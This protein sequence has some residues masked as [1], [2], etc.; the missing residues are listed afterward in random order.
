MKKYNIL[1][2]CAVLMLGSCGTYAGSG[3]YTGGSLGSILGSTIGGITG[4]ARGSD[5]GSIIG[6]AGGAAVGAAIGT[7]ADQR[8][9]QEVH[10][11][12]EQVQENKARGVNPYNDDTYGLDRGRGNSYS[13]T[14]T[15]TLVDGTDNSG[16]D[17]SGKGDDR[18]YDFQSSD[19][20]GDYSAAQPTTTIPTLSSMENLA[21]PYSFAS[22]IEI[23]NAR[24]VDDNQDGMLSA[25]EIG[26]VIFEIYNRGQQTIYDVQPS[27]IEST[28]NRHIYISPSIHVESIAP[29]K[30]IRYTAVI[31]ADKKLKNGTSKFAL[32]VLQ[33]N[34][35][36]SKV[37]EFDI[38]TQK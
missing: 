3:A 37:T 15:T 7:K 2:L 34:K 12:Y 22:N 8:E 26:K 36:I 32:T 17:A 25:N 38:Q 20:T 11:H 1:P 9:R 30:G 16:F 33:G 31:K 14:D 23:E 27:V 35:S 19:Y 28:G 4:G 13:D 18:I 10:D 5:W 6:M 29:G 21:E 24:F